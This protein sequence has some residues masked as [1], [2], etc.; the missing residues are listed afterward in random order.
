[1]YS[2]NLF[3]KISWL[4]IFNLVVALIA[5]STRRGLDSIFFDFMPAIYVFSIIL[6]LISGILLILSQNKDRS[7]QF[8]PV[9]LIGSCLNNIAIVLVFGVTEYFRHSYG[10]RQFIDIFEM[11][12]LFLPLF[13]A[14]VFGGLIGLVIRGTSEQFKKY[15]NLKIII[16]FRKIFGCIF[17]G[18]GIL[19]GLISSA[20]FL[21]LF[22]NPS[23]SWLNIIMADRNTRI[24]FLLFI[25]GVGFI[26]YSDPS[27]VFSELGIEIIFRKKIC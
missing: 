4:I 10:Y 19:G 15:S 27:G 13:I 12:E 23:N 25:A 16:A 20:A 3:K 7:Y 26:N 17:I 9:L 22:F 5:T 21:V 2:K 14:S 6:P 24:C 18:V 8:L 11:T 1:M